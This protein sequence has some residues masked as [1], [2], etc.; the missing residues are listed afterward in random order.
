MVCFLQRKDR[1][2]YI[3]QLKM[4]SWQSDSN[5]LFR[6]YYYIAVD[7][8]SMLVYDVVYHS[9]LHFYGFFLQSEE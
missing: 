8:V 5:F 2:P 6:R 4:S 3:F 1:L 7:G 9:N